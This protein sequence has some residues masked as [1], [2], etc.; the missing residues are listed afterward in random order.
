VKLIPL[1]LACL[2]LA[3]GGDAKCEKTYRV[4][5]FTVGKLDDKSFNEGA[6]KGIL[7]ASDDKSLCIATLPV[8]SDVLADSRRNLDTLVSQ[9]HD[10]IITLGFQLAEDT[11]AVAKAN[12]GTKFAIVDV[13]YEQQVP[14]LVGLTYRED[15]AGFLAGALAGLLTKTNTVGGVY[16]LDIPPVRRFRTG[17]ENGAKHTNPAVMV[18][19]AY[20]PD[21]AKAF[22]D[23][24]WGKAR[25]VEMIAMGADLVFGAGG[26]TGN[27]ALLA[28]DAAGK[29]C[30]GVDV[31]QYYSFPEARRC[32]V[33]SAEKKISESTR[34]IVT[35]AAKGQ[36]PVSGVETF[37]VKNGG[38]GIAP[39][40]D[41]DAQIPAE[42]KARLEEIKAQLADGTLATGA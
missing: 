1:V 33:T 28:A 4:A 34:S 29:M 39:F 23:P 5:M 6:W 40:H 26:H 18:L 9:R 14:N 12:G 31:D 7:A 22:E 21:P 19:G 16:G 20:H 32:L 2:A 35:K 8:T 11:L 38:V 13:A 17:F 30:I 10:L 37:D 42:A 24:E 25:A 15:Q 27:G 41:H 36:W 3:C